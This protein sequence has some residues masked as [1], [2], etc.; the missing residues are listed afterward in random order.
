[1]QVEGTVKCLVWDLD[2]TLWEGT[3]LEDP[4]VRVRDGVRRVM[5]ELD[6]RGILQSVASRNDHDQAWARLEELG[7]AEYLVLPM[8]GWGPK[9]DSVRRI[10]DGLSFAHD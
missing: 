5:A 2:E 1:M 8:I 7:V 9:S 6:S 3:L 10:A 4:D